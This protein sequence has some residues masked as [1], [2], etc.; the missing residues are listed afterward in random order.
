MCAPQTN[1]H[2]GRRKA[3]ATLAPAAMDTM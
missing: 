2:Q 3:A 1:T